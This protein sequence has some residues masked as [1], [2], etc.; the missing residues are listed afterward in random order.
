MKLH[1]IGLA[2]QGGG[3]HG[4]FTWGVLE[5]LLEEESLD[6]EGVTGTSAGAMNAL[7]MAQGW[8]EDGRKGAIKK[9][10]LFWKTVAEQSPS[11]WLG[12][13]GRASHSLNQML[14]ALSN[15]VSP[16]QLNPLDYNPLRKIVSDLC[17][18]N[19]L[20]NNCPFKLFIAA[21][22]VK[23][24]KIR[25][26]R[27]SELDEPHVLASACLPTIQK[28]VMIDGEPY[29]DGGF[30]GN[31]AVYP[32]VFDCGGD[33]ILIVHIEPLSID[34][35]PNSASKISDR[36]AEI[37]FQSTFMREMRAIAYTFKNSKKSRFLSWLPGTLEHRFRRLRFH[38][39]ESTEYMANMPRLS[40]IDT[41]WV[42]LNELKAR[43]KFHAGSWLE[44][45]GSLIG[46]TSSFDIEE[47]F[48]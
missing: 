2:L 29:W 22:Q 9:L 45:S 7:M 19:D 41:R 8:L 12:A 30:S 31:P 10:D 20:R 34:H 15:R 33:D 42:F 23:T 6:F 18:F 16:Y 13:A 3:A 24:G 39:I 5:R 37:G 35:I 43:G 48:L 25:L 27:E 44:K 28:A 36:V 47:A 21:T 4:A 1:R 26:F 14:M 32:L 11:K 40:R 17:D 38:M 46:R